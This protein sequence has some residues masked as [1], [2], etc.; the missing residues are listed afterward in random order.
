MA[1]ERPVY[2]FDVP[3]RIAA[4]CGVKEIGMSQLTAREQLDAIDRAQGKAAKTAIEYIYCSLR[5]MDGT[6]LNMGDGSVE[7]AWA[8]CSPALRELIVAAYGDLH[9]PQEGEF[10]A[11]RASRRV[12]VG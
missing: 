6:K 1:D 5:S 2:L 9:N 3:T 4:E 10:E 11:F 7:K 12:V 8:K